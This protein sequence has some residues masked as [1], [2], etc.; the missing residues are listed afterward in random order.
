LVVKP[1]LMFD[2]DSSLLV[3][4]GLYV[5]RYES[6]GDKTVPP[7]AV[8][9]P[10]HGS[11]SDI[12]II[13]AP[14]CA[15]GRLEQPGAAILVRAADHGKLQIG[16][17]RKGSNGSLDAAFRLESV[18]SLSAGSQQDKGGRRP[19][20]EV[21]TVA[22]SVIAAA[23]SRA[24]SKA[25]FLA[26][27]SRRGDV[28]VTPGEWAAGPDAPGRIEGLELRTLE[29]EGVHAELQVLAANR[30]ANWS[31]WIG[32]GAFAGSR[33]QNRALAG[34]RLRLTGDHAHRFIVDAEALFLG[35]AI[36]NKRGRE[37]ECVS[38]A[39]RDPLVGFRFDVCPERRAGVRAPLPGRDFLS[40]RDTQ[41]RVRVFRAAAAGGGT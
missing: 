41:P 13:S 33:G 9:L 7:T 34:V 38:L 19:H 1:E 21:E 12:E 36:V 4:P 35:S 26:H 23:D 31:A 14:G 22:S 10:A 20:A 32:V 5:L 16:V 2:R 39:G 28:W 8:V 17:K 40:A 11:E 37:V 18:G 15:S 24:S 29:K 30:D 27:I 3:A 25:L 6:A